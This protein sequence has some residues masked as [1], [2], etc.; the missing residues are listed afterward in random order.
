MM[1]GFARDY[2]AIGQHTDG[3]MRE[4]AHADSEIAAL[5]EAQVIG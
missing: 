4:M 5:Q 1:H 3:I 2:Q